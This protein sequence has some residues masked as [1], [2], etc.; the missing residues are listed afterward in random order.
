MPI[1]LTF[2]TDNQPVGVYGLGRTGQS[3]VEALTNSGLDFVTWDDDADNRQLAEQNNW[4]IT[5]L[6]DDLSEIGSLIVSSGMEINHPAVLQAQELDIPIYGDMAL[7][8]RAVRDDQTVIGITGTNGKSTTTALIGHILNFSGRDVATGGNLNPPALSL[9]VHADIYVLEMSSYQLARL[10][11]PLCDIAILLNLSPDHLD[12][13]GGM[14]DYAAAKK[15]IFIPDD[16]QIAV[17]GVDTPRTR[18]IADNL[19]QSNNHTVIPVSV[20]D[21]LS[22]GIWVDGNGIL[23]DPDN[24]AGIDLMAAIALPG[25]HNWQNIAHAYAV[26]KTMN[27]P[28]RVIEQAIHEFPGLIHRQQ[29]VAEIDDI[30][31]VNDSK[32]TNA[33]ATKYALRARDN[34]FWILGGMEKKGGLRGLEDEIGSV[35]KAYLIGQAADEFSTWLSANDIDHEACDILDRAVEHAFLDADQSTARPAT[36]LLSPA[37]ASFDQYDNFEQRG[38]HFIRLIKDLEQHKNDIREAAG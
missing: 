7:M 13:H 11:T 8:A 18:D 20:T 1:D 9:P 25:K 27:V 5:D 15:N 37:C 21:Q 35:R 28:T 6:S 16:D 12:W 24:D 22:D 36:V 29:L 31:F 17:I 3:A 10:D 30:R 2:L 19:R 26:A 4:P 14:D 23:H 32:A 33:D 38:N 34:I